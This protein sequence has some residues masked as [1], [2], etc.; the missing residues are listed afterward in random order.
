MINYLDFFL[1]TRFTPYQLKTNQTQ[2]SQTVLWDNEMVCGVVGRGG[3]ERYCGMNGVDAGG[4]GWLDVV[5]DAWG[6]WGTRGDVGVDAGARGARRDAQLGVST[7]ATSMQYATSYRN[8]TAKW[9]G[10]TK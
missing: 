8:A 6:T 10:T 1:K 3:V 2:I 4:R 5:G 9:N 7:N